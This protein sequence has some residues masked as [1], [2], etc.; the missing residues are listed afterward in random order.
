MAQAGQAAPPQS[1]PVSEPFFFMS[2]QPDAVAPPLSLF[3]P[4]SGAL[5]DASLRP[6]S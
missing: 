4:A 1:V 3:A 5:V 6:P 2:L